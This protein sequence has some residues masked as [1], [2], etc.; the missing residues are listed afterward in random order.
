[1]NV[2]F[3][4]KKALTSLN[5]YTNFGRVSLRSVALLKEKKKKDKVDRG[6]L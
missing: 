4:I 3:S 5:Y 6:V 1:M 2:H